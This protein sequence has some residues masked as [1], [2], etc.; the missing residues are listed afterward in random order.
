VN[1]LKNAIRAEYGIKV[2]MSGIQNA[3]A[4]GSSHYVVVIANMFNTD[5]DAKASNKHEISLAS[6]FEVL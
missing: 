5:E 2:D 3:S 6:N 4:K 1:E